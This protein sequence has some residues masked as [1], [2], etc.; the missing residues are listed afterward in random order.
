METYL[1]VIAE[2]TRSV[3]PGQLQLSQD[4]AEH[5]DHW[6]DDSPRVALDHLIAA[7]GRRGLGT[8]EMVMLPVHEVDS[9]KL[10]NEF[11]GYRK[12]E[13]GEALHYFNAD[14]GM[15]EFIELE[16]AERSGLAYRL[17][18]WD[19]RFS[20]SEGTFEEKLI[21]DRPPYGFDSIVPQQPLS[22]EEYN[23][24]VD[25]TL[26]FVRRELVHEHSRE[27]DNIPEEDIEIEQS[28][29]GE[30]AAADVTVTDGLIRCSVHLPLPDP[31]DHRRRN[32]VQDVYGVYEGNTVLLIP[33]QEPRSDEYVDGII[34]QISKDKIYIDPDFG[35]RDLHDRSSIDFDEC[36]VHVVTKGI[37]EQR[38]YNAFSNSAESYRDLL[39]GNREVSFTSPLDVKFEQFLELNTYQERAAEAALRTDDVFCIHGPPGTG[40]T[41]T[42]VNII[43]HATKQGDTVLVCAHSNQAVDNIVAG[44]STDSKIDPASLHNIVESI[45][46]DDI[47]LLRVGSSRKNVSSFVSKNYFRRTEYISDTDISPDI[48]ASTT[49]SAAAIDNYTDIDFDLVVIDEATQASG[50]ATA[51]PFGWGHRIDDEGEYPQPYGLRT[52]LAGD[53]KQLPP[54]VSDPEMREKGVHTS[55]FEHLLNVYG[56][57]ISQ[58]LHRQYRM[59]EQIAEFASREFYEG[60]LEHGR[61]NRDWSIDG[62]DPILGIDDSGNEEESDS[63]Y[64]NPTEAEYVLVQ[65]RKSLQQGVNPE[66]IGIITGYSGQRK[67]LRDEIRRE[68]DQ[69]IASAIDVETIDKFQGGQREVIII[70]FVRSNPSHNSGFLEHPVDEGRKRLNVALTRAKKRLVL[71]GDWNTLTNTA[72]FRKEEE[73]CADTFHRLKDYLEEKDALVT[74]SR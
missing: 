49:N 17:R 9:P 22:D 6:N 52:V 33:D 31:S 59:N 34:E 67:H 30:I 24:Y 48:I 8:G 13:Y 25:E 57:D 50:P 39:K 55:M 29:D 71:I 4:E 37:A 40:K 41:R 64:Y 36:A 70:S 43:A 74:N 58:T 35:V 69:D 3:S 27:L 72:E 73:S 32:T 53:H 38:E 47:S 10:T 28:M 54:F 16:N 44:E 46:D 1:D 2:R 14:N 5:C 23:R 7:F 65:V 45:G 51:V 12:D 42:L 18:F 63:S 11:I 21:D 66:D 60:E 19:C 68:F 15:N 62:L 20:I 56:T 26:E 61:E